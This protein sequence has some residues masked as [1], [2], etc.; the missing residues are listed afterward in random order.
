M[1]EPV[2]LCETGNPTIQSPL[3]T[4]LNDKFQLVL[5]LPY[6]LRKESV[7]D[8]KIS[9]D[10]VQ[11]TIFGTVVPSIQVPPQ[12]VMFSGQAYNVTSYTR[13]NY[14]PLDV[15]FIV[16]NQFKNYWILWKWLSVLNNPAESM[17]NGTDPRYETWKDRIEN[18]TL[19]EYQ[20]NFSILSKNEYNQTIIEFRYSNAFITTLG[21]I[22]YNYRNSEIIE[23]SAQ[24]QFSQLDIIYTP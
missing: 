18:G 14:A 1:N 19:T 7:T 11:L 13:P 22:N 16:D 23:S 20:S 21:G 15:N 9:L 10:P 2:N 24:F 6:I 8:P 5:N 17:Y 4:G 3:N 12:E